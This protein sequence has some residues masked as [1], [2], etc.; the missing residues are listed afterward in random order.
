[1]Q[2]TTQNQGTSSL[3]GNTANTGTTNQSA[4]GIANQAG[5]SNLS[6]DTQGTSTLTGQNV[7][8]NQA[9]PFATVLGLLGGVGNAISTWNQNNP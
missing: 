3:L 4:L 6:S 7:V 2:G 5:Q 1:M 8:Q 9:N